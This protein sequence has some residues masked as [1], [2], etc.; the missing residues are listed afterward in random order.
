[1]ALDKIALALTVLGGLNWGSVGIFRFDII[2]R[3][4]G[5]PATTAAR[6]VYTLIGIA[7]IWSL[8]LLFRE[9]EP[10]SRQA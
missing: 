3:L 5:G 8:T 1:M 7:A 4:C 2:A 10:H 6:V 9:R